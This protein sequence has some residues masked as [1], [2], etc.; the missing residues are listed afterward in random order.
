MAEMAG[1]SG[2]MARAATGPAS[3]ARG[4]AATGLRIGVL[5]AA[6]ASRR[7]GR[8]KALIAGPGRQ[9][10]LA[11]LVETLRL[12]GC[13]AVIAVAGCHVSEIA[14]HLPRGALLVHNEGWA[15]GQLASVRRGLEAA[16]DLSPSRIALHL[17]DQPL[18][19]AA[20]V[21]AVLDGEASAF[22][23]S[24]AAHRGE[25]GHPLSLSPDLARAIAGDE[26]SATLREALD[27]H[28]KSRCL[29]RGTAGCVRGANT[30]EELRALGILPPPIAASGPSR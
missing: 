5:L 21:R 9:T 18:I 29:V 26:I 25:P 24:I 3:G 1:D 17:V 10:F 14:A 12:G 22:P 30:P 13:D 19:A 7:M 11:H 4:E 15:L 28:A 8:P 6:G 2:G 27:R 20:D 16:L 23:L